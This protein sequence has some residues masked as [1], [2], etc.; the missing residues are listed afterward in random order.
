[1]RKL[2][3]WPALAALGL[4]LYGVAAAADGPAAGLTLQVGS[5]SI[6]TGV[7]LGNP[8]DIALL[9]NGALL[10]VDVSQQIQAGSCLALVSLATGICVPLGPGEPVSPD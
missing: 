2:L 10:S 1:M 7:A 4:G 8:I 3:A 9:A 6:S 5:L